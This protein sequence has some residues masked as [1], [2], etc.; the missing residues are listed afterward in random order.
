MERAK[1][2][3]IGEDE[4]RT[5]V[6]MVIALH[7]QENTTMAEQARQAAVDELYGLGYDYRKTFDARIHAVKLEDVAAAARK[8]LGNHVLVTASPDWLRNRK[9][10]A[11]LRNRK[12]FDP[13]PD[14]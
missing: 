9:R 3:R 4:F 1:A 11:T 13:D 10:R 5:A 6:Q 12:R 14:P 2:G 8:Y 7:A